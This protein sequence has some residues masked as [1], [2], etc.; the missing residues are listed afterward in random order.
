MSSLKNSTT[1]ETPLYK[2]A[3]F[4]L[5][6][7][8]WLDRPTRQVKPLLKTLLEREDTML[9]KP[10]DWPKKSTQRLYPNPFDENIALKH[11][12]KSTHSI[13]RGTCLDNLIDRNITDLVSI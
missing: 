8:L 12:K 11:K 6:V 10:Q 9:V 5:P 2:W 3:S 1:G 13:P 7:V 4:M